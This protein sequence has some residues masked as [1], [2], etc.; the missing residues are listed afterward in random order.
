[1][2][3][4]MDFG[5]TLVRLEGSLCVSSSCKHI[6]VRHSGCPAGFLGLR[7][8]GRLLQD[9]ED[10][11]QVWSKRGPRRVDL[12]PEPQGDTPE[13]PPQPSCSVPTGP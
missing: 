13:V 2:P 9:R 3:V 4:Q 12:N 6:H 8:E 1:M 7:P 11:R 10:R 5:L